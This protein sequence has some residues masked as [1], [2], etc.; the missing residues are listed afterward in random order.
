MRD[1]SV[2][3][4]FFRASGLN[5]LVAAINLWNTKYLDV[6]N[7]DLKRQGRPVNEDLLRHVAPLPACLA[8]TNGSV[9]ASLCR[10]DMHQE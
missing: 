6:A 1:R 8:A 2:E 4:Q 3:N 9:N 7:A 10:D 5:L